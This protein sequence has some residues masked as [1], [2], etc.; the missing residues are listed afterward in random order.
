[1]KQRIMLIT[2]TSLLSLQASAAAQY[3]NCATD[4]GCV[5]AGHATMH[6][7]YAKTKYPLVLAHG[8]A[9]FSSV[10]SISS[11]YAIPEDLIQQG[12]TVYNTKVSAFETSD[13]RGE[14]LLQ[15]VEEIVSLAPQQKVNLIGQSHGGQ[16]IRYV[17]GVAPQYV[18]SVTTIG[19]PH[20]G[21]PVANLIK[22][23]LEAPVTTVLSPLVTS[24]ANGWGVFVNLV[25]GSGGEYPQNAL[26]GINSITTAGSAQFNQRFPL[27]LPTTSCGSGQTQVNGIRLY[28]WSGTRIFTNPLDVS[29]TV[30]AATNLAFMGEA[31]DGLVGRCSSRF[32][33][34][35]R[36]NY[37][38]N[39]VDQI[40][41]LFGLVSI[42]ETNPKTIYRQHANRLK[43]VGL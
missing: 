41:H 18:A 17:L 31:N 1:M 33:H 29:D 16:S 32:G 11:F 34:V 2:T 5:L 15:Q 39:H 38:L 25:S 10:G 40:N 27:G 35:I 22:T 20:Q 28:S 23:T 26:A 13:I 36:D 7:T 43:N 42:F 8:M 30:L 4:R 14:Q 21:T 37:R 6:S 24:V 12:A 9:G 19:S 3:Y